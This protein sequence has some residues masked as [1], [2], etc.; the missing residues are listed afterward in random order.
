MILLIDDD[1]IQHVITKIIMRKHAPELTLDT[2]FSAAEALE[3]IRGNRNCFTNLPDLVLLDLNM[4]GMNGL[5]FLESLSQFW[6]DLTKKVRV[7]VVSSSLDKAEQDRAKSYDFVNDFI[8]KPF[9]FEQIQPY[10][11]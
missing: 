3:E 1:N 9:T 11:A 5:Q 4:P 7:V 2:R 6:S 10:L 8:C